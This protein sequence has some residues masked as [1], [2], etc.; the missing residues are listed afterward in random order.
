MNRRQVPNHLV[1]LIGE[2]GMNVQDATWDCHGTPVIYHDALERLAEHLGIK[3]SPPVI[4]EN[5]SADRIVALMVEGFEGENH[6]WSIGECSPANIKNAYP[7]A[8]AEKR[9][10]DRVTL[11]LIGASGFVY[12]EEESD[13]F[14]NPNRFENKQQSQRQ[15]EQKEK[16][17]A[18]GEEPEGFSFIKDINSDEDKRNLESYQLKIH[19]FPWHIDKFVTYAHANTWWKHEEVFL[20]EIK[21]KHPRDFWIIQ[22]QFREK[23]ATLKTGV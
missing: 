5:N 12:S 14:K 22:K 23:W 4:I 15:P 3:F 10:K 13:D 7:Y 9:A 16:P 1:E 21:E 6:A 2:I 8:M 17:Q 11:K 20:M 18:Q 19:E